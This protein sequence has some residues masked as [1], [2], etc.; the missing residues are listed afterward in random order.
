MMPGEHLDGSERTQENVVQGTTQSTT[1]PAL[2]PGLSRKLI[3]QVGTPALSKGH[4]YLSS[5][6]VGT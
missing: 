6:Q 3:N 5:S 1:P 2:Y 4:A